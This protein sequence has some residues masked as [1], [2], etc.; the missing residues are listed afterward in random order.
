MNSDT[1]PKTPAA[2]RAEPPKLRAS[3]L[4]VLLSGT[5]LLATGAAEAAISC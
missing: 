4:A 5:A 2:G 3:W 1:F